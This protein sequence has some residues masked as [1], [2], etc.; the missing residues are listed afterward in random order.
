MSALLN[1]RLPCSKRSGEHC[2]TCSDHQI[3]C[4]FASGPLGAPS[5]RVIKLTAEESV[6][7]NPGSGTLSSSSVS[8]QYGGGEAWAYS[9]PSI[10]QIPHE[11]QQTLAATTNLPGVVHSVVH[12]NSIIER[13][14][15]QPLPSWLT[16]LINTAGGISS[17]ISGLGKFHLIMLVYSCQRG[18]GAV[19]NR[20]QRLLLAFRVSD[21][22]CY[23]AKEIAVLNTRVMAG[24]RPADAALARLKTLASRPL[25]KNLMKALGTTMMCTMLMQKEITPDRQRWQAGSIV[26]AVTDLPVASDITNT[27]SGGFGHV[28]VVLPRP[29]RVHRSDKIIEQLNKGMVRD[30]LPCGYA[31]SYVGAPLRT[32]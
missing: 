4:I 23:T 13:P 31:M 2:V 7:Y 14:W 6:A 3:F 17:F 32:P 5:S 21:N 28:N 12:R 25:A 15:L 10:T 1:A 18:Q 16:Q 27:R 11:T 8:P 29:S 20:Y 19:S 22:Y 26:T 24:G 30:S 9:G